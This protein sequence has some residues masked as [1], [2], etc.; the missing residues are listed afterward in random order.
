[1]YPHNHTQ[2]NRPSQKGPDPPPVLLL[3][4]QQ[5]D[6]D[7]PNNL[8]DPI[9]GIVQGPTLDIKQD[10]V[11]IAELPGVEIIAGEEHGKEEDD[12]RIGFEGDKEAFE[13]G[14]P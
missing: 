14:F 8:G 7:A 9:H 11:V 13:F 4:Q 5:A 12:E 10:C 6:G 1:M 2:Q 3:I